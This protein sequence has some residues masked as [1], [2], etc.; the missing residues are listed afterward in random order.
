M[1][2]LLFILILIYS[3][4]NDAQN[5]IQITPFRAQESSVF[6]HP[7]NPQVVLVANNL[8]LGLTP[9]LINAWYSLDG[10]ITWTQTSPLFFTISPNP[11]FSF[12]IRYWGLILMPKY[13]F[14]KDN[15][16]TWYLS[17]GIKIGLYR[18]DYIKKR[19][20]LLWSLT[21]QS[22]ATISAGRNFKLS[23]NIFFNLE[24]D[25]L[26]FLKP[27]KRSK[28]IT[29]Q[30]TTFSYMQPGNAIPYYYTLNWPKMNAAG[31]AYL[32]SIGL[33]AGLTIKL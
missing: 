1:R 16:P 10:G 11:G 12:N 25:F 13:N 14:Y 3:I 28:N 15:H 2:N 17:G 4:I 27:V 22:L 8:G 29:I 33:N 19:D 31:K 30:P 21:F 5:D 23:K 18:Q 32:Y 24:S 9:F 6:I 20:D 7:N 26:C